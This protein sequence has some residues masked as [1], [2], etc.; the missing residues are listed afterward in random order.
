M[1]KY[2]I[3]ATLLLGTL[4]CSSSKNSA[5]ISPDAPT[6]IIFLIGDGMGLSAVSSSFYFEA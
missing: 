5:D 1:I 6:N 2:Y 3:S 4:A